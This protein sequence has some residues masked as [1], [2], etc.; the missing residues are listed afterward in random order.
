MDHNI[1]PAQIPDHLIGQ[2]RYWATT[3]ELAKLTGSSLPGLYSSL[4]SLEHANKLFTPAKGL[5]VA[6]PPDY[7]SWGAVPADW[8]IDPMMRH[9]GRYYYVAFLS[10]AARHGASHQAPQAFQVIVDRPL[11]D[12]DI[13]R[14]HLRFTTSEDAEH[15]AVHRATTHTGYVTVA[16][17]EATVVDL[18]WKP[19]AGAGLNNVATVL[20][21][22]GTLDG[23]SLA[24]LAEYRGRCVARRIGWLLTHFRPDVDT[25]WLKLVAR[26]DEGKATLL[27]PGGPPSRG[28]R[29]KAW[30]VRV[31][32]TVEP[33]L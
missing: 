1:S 27:Q 23:D 21:G 13:G 30:N 32:A 24:R 25:H 28:H 12:R 11:R 15:M 9:L 14:I 33:D 26:P 19:R 8:F 18:A 20:S 10:A 6:V 4:A 2:G 7:R 22:L 29:D 31:N 3:A 16:T 5:Y 17:P